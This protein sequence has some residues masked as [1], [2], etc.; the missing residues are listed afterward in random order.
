M[1]AYMTLL[2][3]AAALVFGLWLPWYLKK[4]KQQWR[5][6]MDALQD[7][8]R[9]IIEDIKLPAFGIAS[10]RF[11]VRDAAD[12]WRVES[13]FLS[14]AN[15]SGST[16]GQQVEFRTSYS[17]AEGGTLVIG[18]PMPKVDLGFMSSMM[19][20]LV[21]KF[22]AKVSGLPEAD[23]NGLRMIETTA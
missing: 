20:M 17:K 13:R 2:I 8:Y 18:P 22:L 16:A 10:S 14:G 23:L 19:G 9:W 11:T 3:F 7:R 4:Q 15:I 1:P 12:R 6:G 21:V 5:K